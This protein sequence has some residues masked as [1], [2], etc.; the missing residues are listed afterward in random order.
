MKDNK[1]NAERCQYLDINE[2]PYN[3]R[4]ECPQ[5]KRDCH[6]PLDNELEEA[7]K[8][9][10][11]WRSVLLASGAVI[12]LFVIEFSHPKSESLIPWFEL[13]TA[14]CI[15]ILAGVLLA[16][17]VDIPKKFDEY[18][19]LISTS[20]TS[21]TYL[22]GLNKEE[23]A[24]LR[25]RVT[26]ELYMKNAPKMPR[27][28]IKLDNRVCEL[29]ANPYYEIYRETIHCGK[30]DLFENLTKKKEGEEP[31]LKE[32]VGKVSGKFIRKIH[33]QVYTIKN[34][35]SKTQPIKANIGLNSYLYLPENS[36]MDEL[37]KIELFQLSI[38]GGD[39]IDITPM[40]K[41]QYHQYSK[42]DN[43]IPDASTYNFGIHL[44]AKDNKTI[45]QESLFKMPGKEGIVYEETS[46]AIGDT[47]LIVSFSD[48]VSVKMT[49][50]LIVPIEDN[51]FTK[52][53]KYSTKSYRLDYSIEDEANCVIGQ[54]FGALIDQSQVLLTKTDNGKHI[55]IE[56]FEWLLPKSGAFV[57]WSKR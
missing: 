8:K 12:V 38:D 33:D 27:G 26:A 24:E 22:R 10:F 45:T 5:I 34:P 35:Y 57:V 16:W 31:E 36:T 17:L 13:L 29:L 11:P 52:R 55:S 54:L 19:R 14:G 43:R 21:Y 51:H 6:L 7:P 50:N 47:Q 53:L 46:D 4:K 56:A 41:V 2:C 25:G 20:L 28:L 48:S 37:L 15:S 40:L 1:K 49:F 39:Y 23:L 3:R 32:S 42:A 30:P 9:K 18:T 44:S